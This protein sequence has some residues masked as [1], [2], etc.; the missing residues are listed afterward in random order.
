[1]RVREGVVKIIVFEI[2][3]SPELHSNLLNVW[4]DGRREGNNCIHIHPMRDKEGVLGERRVRLTNTIAFVDTN[5]Q[6][7]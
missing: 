1:M 3:L 4:V 6:K 5:I 2:E 7:G